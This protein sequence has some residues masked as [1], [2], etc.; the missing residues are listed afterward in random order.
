MNFAI[1]D[2]N[3]ALRASTSNDNYPDDKELPFRNDPSSIEQ[4]AS[5]MEDEDETA[6]VIQD[7]IRTSEG[8]NPLR[9]VETFGMQQL[10]HA[11]E[12]D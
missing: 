7:R 12:V 3:N 8:A 5:H 6:F 4:V 10:D 2:N 11:Y 1:D 9:A